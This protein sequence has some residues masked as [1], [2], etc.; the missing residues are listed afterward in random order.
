ME[1]NSNDIVNPWE[2]KGKIDYDRL[3]KEFGVKYITEEQ[4]EYLISLSKKKGLPVHLFLKRGLFFAQMDLDK[5]IEAHKSGK[6]IFLYTGRAPGGKMHIGHL[7]P[8]KFTKYLQD[9]FDANLY[10]QIPDDEKYLFKKNLTL[11]DINVAVENDLIDIAAIGFNPNKTFIFRNSEYIRNMYPLVISIAKRIT[12]SQARN[13]FGFEGS[14]NIGQIF[15]PSLQIAPTMFQKGIC[16]IPCAID[17]NPYFLLQRD[18]ANKLGFEKNATILSKFLPPLTGVEGKMSASDESKAILLI[19][20]FNKIKKKVNKYA[21]SGGQP[22]IEEHRKYGGNCEIDVSFQWLYYL[23]EEDDKEI[24]KIRK[25]YSSGEMLSGELKKLLIGKLTEFIEEHKK[26]K[27]KVIKENLIEK[28]MK[29]G[30]L[31][32]EMLRKIH[33]L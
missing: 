30:E 31:A 13:V 1:N 17:Q 14:S 24:E 25:L 20:D 7:I 26:Q 29:T 23:F 27:E 32:K 10:I 16:L 19:D 2:V 33:Q 9:L 11:E 22:T 5:V 21:F 6:S 3:V 4:K 18:I 28:Y 8:F 15:Y 12:F